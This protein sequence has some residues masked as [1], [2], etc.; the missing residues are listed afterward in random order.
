MRSRSP[1]PPDVDLTE[2]WSS[3]DQP[4]AIPE[5]RLLIAI[6]RRAVYDFILY[7]DL[8]P[9]QP[10]ADLAEDAAG[11]LFWDGEEEL[12]DEGRWTFRH[13]CTVLSIDHVRLRRRTLALTRDD[14]KR[15]NNMGK[16]E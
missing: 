13:I 11:W 15:L 16:K 8:Q 14:I 5:Q 4:E 3:N 6:L 2:F 9:G 7:R 1:S 10:N 12:D